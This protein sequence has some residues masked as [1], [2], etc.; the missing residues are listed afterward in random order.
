MPGAAEPVETKDGFHTPPK[1]EQ[2]ARRDD[3]I[4]CFIVSPL[5]VH[6]RFLFRVGP[7]SSNCHSRHS[8]REP[9]L[10]ISNAGCQS[11]EVRERPAIARARVLKV[12]F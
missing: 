9:G 2:L 5:P 3:L 4:V 8:Y 7:S 11:Q 1:P 10:Y 12:Y 6:K